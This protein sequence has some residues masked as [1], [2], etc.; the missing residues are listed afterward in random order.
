MN[1]CGVCKYYDGKYVHP[2]C[3][4]CEEGSKFKRD[5]DK[6]I[7]ALIE[8]DDIKHSLKI[9]PKYFN[10]VNEGRKTFE[11][12]KDDR[13]FKVGDRF[14]LREYKDGNYTGRTFIGRISYILRECS[15]YGLQDGYCIFGW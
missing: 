8:C 9:L 15:E 4:E 14:I 10:E 13:N 5:N 6:L 12:R 7:E 1:R 3:L 11:L 2:N